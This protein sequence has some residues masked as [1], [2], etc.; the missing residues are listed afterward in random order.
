MEKNKIEVID[1]YNEKKYAV[2]DSDELKELLESFR[3]VVESDWQLND[4]QADAENYRLKKLVCTCQMLANLAD[5][6]AL[7]LSCMFNALTCR[8]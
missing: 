1:Q 5:D 3:D 6:T 7:T 8:D 2:K 4:V